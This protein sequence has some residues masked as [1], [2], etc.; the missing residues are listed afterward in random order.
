MRV[1][2]ISKVCLTSRLNIRFM[3]E[4]KR[5]SSQV[6]NFINVLRANFTYKSLFGSFFYLHVTR[7]KLLK[8]CHT[9]NSRIKCWW[10][11]HKDGKNV[12]PNQF[13]GGK[14]FKFLSGFGDLLPPIFITTTNALKNTSRTAQA[15]P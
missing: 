1:A 8:R 3:M 15:W 11:W 4:V 6:V 12:W 9:K 5:S 7:E 14:C 2:V 13:V 10:N